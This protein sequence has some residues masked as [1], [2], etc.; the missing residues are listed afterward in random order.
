MVNSGAPHPAGRY[1]ERGTPAFWRASIALLVAGYATLSLLYCAQPLMPVFAEAFGVTPGQS[2]LALSVTTGTLALSIFV[3]GFGSEAWG[4]RG[5]MTTSMAAAALL[6]ML[7]AVVPHWSQL[8]LV[9]ALAGIALGGVP[10][11]AMAYLAEEIH[12][13]GLGLAMGIYVAGSALGGMGGRVITAVAADL[14]GWR[15]ALGVIGAL[16]LAATALFYWLL[17][18]SRNF[19]PRRGVGAAQ[20][21]ATLIG[22]LA[23]P[24]LPWLF[25][26]AFLGMGSF[27]TVYNYVGFRLLLAPF[28][29]SQGAIGSIFVVYMFGIVA[30]PWAGRL[31]DRFGRGVVMTGGA[32]VMGAGVACTLSDRLPL[33][34]TGIAAVTCGFFAVHSVA[35]AWVGR[36]AKRAKGQSAALYL[37]AYYGGS[38]VMGA[39]GGWFWARWAWPGVA[40]LVAAL[41][42][43]M[44]AI[45]LWL[46]AHEQNL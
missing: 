26:T 38:S 33:I 14:A 37:L 22:H 29:M 7:T 36:L 15:V 24:G 43:A 31:A 13:D 9:R 45:A 2:S 19:T 25:V 18:P 11:V 20:N 17:P 30:S 41:V 16:G 28:S 42:V 35:S 44:L 4:R 10:A 34:V 12:P 5:L 39:W 21:R 46:A 23:S 40:G 3:A 6:T 1:I 27:V 32:L 8:L